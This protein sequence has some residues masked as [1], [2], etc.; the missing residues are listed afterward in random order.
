[1]YGSS[2]EGREEGT[3]G[4]FPHKHPLGMTNRPVAANAHAR[5]QILL[6]CGRIAATLGTSL[7]PVSAI[8]RSLFKP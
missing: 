3:G 6:M 5:A 1:M 8:G 2:R 7:A 4:S